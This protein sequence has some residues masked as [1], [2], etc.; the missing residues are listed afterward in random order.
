VQW[1]GV[2]INN[3]EC[4]TKQIKNGLIDLLGAAGAM[5]PDDNK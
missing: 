5:T 3:K 2:I 4:T 1:D